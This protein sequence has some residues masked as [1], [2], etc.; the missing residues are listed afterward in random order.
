MALSQENLENGIKNLLDNPNPDAADA[1]EQWKK[2]IVDFFSEIVIAAPPEPTALLPTYKGL[3]Q[4]GI[5]FDG[6]EK[7]LAFSGLLTVAV[8]LAADEVVKNTLP[9]FPIPPPPSPGQ[10]LVSSIP[11][12]K[13]AVPVFE[14]EDDAIGVTSGD[15]AKEISEAIYN[16]AITG[17]T[18]STI[19]PAAPVTVNWS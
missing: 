1:A 12:L 11:P 7:D 5:S 9:V 17:I 6:L 8:T 16:W 10:S 4:S 2:V 19:A 18:E 3:L 13:F 14:T 15:I